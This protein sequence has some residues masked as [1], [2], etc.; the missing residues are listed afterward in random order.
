MTLRGRHPNIFK[1]A[2]LNTHECSSGGT[3]LKR[4][5]GGF[6]TAISRYKSIFRSIV[7]WKPLKTQSLWSTV[8]GEDKGQQSLLLGLASYPWIEIKKWG[9]NTMNAKQTSCFWNVIWHMEK[10]RMFFSKYQQNSGVLPCIAWAKKH[11]S[12]DSVLPVVLQKPYSKPT[13]FY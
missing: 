1:S 3:W 8:P 13:W 5:L 7:L 11:L 9:S 2:A 6:P 10:G 12:V 4:E